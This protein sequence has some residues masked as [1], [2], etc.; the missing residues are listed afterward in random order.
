MS[1]IGS[2]GSYFDFSVFI[3]LALYCYIFIFSA[4]QQGELTKLKVNFQQ[5]SIITRPT[6]GITQD[7][8]KNNITQRS[9]IYTDGTDCYN[10]LAECKN[11]KVVHQP[12]YCI[13]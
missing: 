9:I 4:V 5:A 3:E 12:I 1:L 10:S 11:C 2:K 6:K 8:F 7:T 13:I